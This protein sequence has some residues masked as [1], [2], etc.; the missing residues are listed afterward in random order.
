MV[1]DVTLDFMVMI[2]S[3]ATVE[4]HWDLISLHTKEE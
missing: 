3:F 2:I 4:R 1:I